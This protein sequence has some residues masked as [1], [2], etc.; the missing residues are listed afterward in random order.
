MVQKWHF[1]IYSENT[2]LLVTHS[3]DSI[4]G[5]LLL[6]NWDWGSI[7]NERIKTSSKYQ[8]VFGTESAGL[9]QTFEN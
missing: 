5:G 1:F 9:F 6:F 3:G 7:H 8:S 2:L 4:I